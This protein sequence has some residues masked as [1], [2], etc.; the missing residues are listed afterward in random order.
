MFEKLYPFKQIYKEIGASELISDNMYQEAH[1][2]LNKMSNSLI[3]C[4]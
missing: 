1:E 3:S 2:I 4:L